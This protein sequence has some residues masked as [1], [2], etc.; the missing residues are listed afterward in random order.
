VTNIVDPIASR[1]ARY[2]RVRLGPYKNLE[3]AA[4]IADKVRRTLG[5]APALIQR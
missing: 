5:T 1:S 4:A 2:Y 3:E